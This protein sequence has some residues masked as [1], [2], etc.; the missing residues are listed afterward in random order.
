VRAALEA[1]LNDGSWGR[2]QGRH[3]ERLVAAWAERQQAPHALVC[4][5]GTFAVELALRGLKVE[6]D[7][8]VVL[9][10]YDFPGNFRAIEAIGAVPV[11]VDI[12]ADNWT[13]DPAAVTSA[14]GPRTRAV[15]VSHLHGG[16][17]DMA[18]MRALAD[19]HGIAI[20]E[21]ACQA[22]GASISGRPAGSWGDVGVFSFG[23]SK[24]LTAGRGGAISC[25]DA[26][27]WQRAKIYCQR[28]NHAFPLSEL[29]AAVLLPQ[30]ERLDQDNARRRA[31]AGQLTQRIAGLPGLRPLV[32]PTQP[33]EPSFYKLGLHYEPA[34]LGDCSIE[35]FVAATQAEGVPLD[36]GFRGFVLRSSRRCRRVDDLANSRRA[37]DS[38]LLLHHPILLEPQQTVA[39][40]AEAIAKVCWWMNPGRIARG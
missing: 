11:L 27:V 31:A 32:N 30:I 34:S 8:E 36:R 38:T 18:G 25:R 39:A 33:A 28:G 17:T 35:R 26:D 23:G 29:Q 15:L 5:S 13:L 19:R 3:E 21:D 6:P 24:L 4:C 12:R 9:A 7:E 16:M 37:A 14:L 40:V 20:V 22:P 10:G 1:A 2:Y